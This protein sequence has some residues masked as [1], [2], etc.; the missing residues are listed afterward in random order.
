MQNTV[1]QCKE[2]YFVIENLYRSQW[3]R[4]LWRGCAAVCLLG[5]WVR[6][7][8]EAWMSVSLWELCV[9]RYRSLRRA[10]HSSRGVLLSV[11]CLSVIVKPRQRGGPGALEV[12][13]PMEKKWYTEVRN[14][15]IGSKKTVCSVSFTFLV[16]LQI[17]HVILRITNN[18]RNLWIVIQLKV[19]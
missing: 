3:P 19:W 1:L 6:I 18:K 7:P 16:L 12:V 5:L 17:I 9:V 10:D 13:A 8:P 11:V 2:L 4:G 15:Q 14:E